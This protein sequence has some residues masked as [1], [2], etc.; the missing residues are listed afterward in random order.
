MQRANQ[1]LKTRTK[2]MKTLYRVISRT[3]EIEWDGYVYDS[4]T[5]TWFVHDRCGRPG[6]AYDKLIEGYKIIPSERRIYAECTL[7]ELFTRDE[8]DALTTYLERFPSFEELVEITLPLAEPA[9]PLDLIPLVC[10]ATT[11][12]FFNLGAEKDY[13]LG[14]DV[15]GLYDL[16][17][18]EPKYQLPAGRR[19]GHNPDRSDFDEIPF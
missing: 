18:H 9:F 8:A 1:S 2:N 16:M 14:F 19:F 17:R 15:V 11:H 12:A 6:A 10:G 13:D 7:G 3:A 4:L 5:F